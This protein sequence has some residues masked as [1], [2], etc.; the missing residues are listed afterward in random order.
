MRVF[1]MWIKVCIWFGTRAE[2]EI[3]LG[4]HF[5][6]DKNYSSRET[7]WL[8]TRHL[9]F[10]PHWAWKEAAWASVPRSLLSKS[11]PTYL[12]AWPHWPEKQPATQPNG[13]VICRFISQLAAKTLRHRTSERS[14]GGRRRGAKP[15]PWLDSLLAVKT[16]KSPKVYCL[17]ICKPSKERLYSPW[18]P[19]KAL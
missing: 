18:K 7:L 9:F 5:K 13:T 6:Q 8:Q 12:S 1:K 16:V 15:N 2:N 19:Q 3:C 4:A 17:S 10:V 14:G 11:L